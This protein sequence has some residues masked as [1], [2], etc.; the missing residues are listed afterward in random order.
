MIRQ[1]IAAQPSLRF[2]RSH[3]RDF[4]GYARNFES[5]YRVKTADCTVFVDA[6][7]AIHLEL[8]RRFDARDIDL[9]RPVQS[10]FREGPQG[11]TT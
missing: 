2:E 8:R 10:V 5:V 6:Q 7:Q 1:S 4:A 9:A 3:L 11:V